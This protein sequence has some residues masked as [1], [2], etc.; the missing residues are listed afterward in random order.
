MANNGTIWGVFM[1]KR[2]NRDQLKIED[3]FLP[4]GGKLDANNR[5]VKLAEDTPWDR[6]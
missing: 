3:F 4:F 2:V 5:W 6:I 1:Y